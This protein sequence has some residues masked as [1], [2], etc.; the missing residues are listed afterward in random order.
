MSDL[1]VVVTGVLIGSATGIGGAVLGAW[2]NGR[3]QMAGLKLSI[4]AENERAARAERQRA[5][6]AFLTSVNALSVALRVYPHEA[7]D[8]PKR[9]YEDLK[10]LPAA[11][12]LLDTCNELS[13]IAPFAIMMTA[14]EI[15]DVC[16]G[17]VRRV[18]SG[19]AVPRDERSALP[20]LIN[21][22]SHA[23]SADLGVPHPTHVVFRDGSK[24]M[25]QPDGQTAPQAADRG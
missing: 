22:I 6:V 21:R 16:L 8:S 4:A 19:G 20:G 3:S 13:L 23:M 11:Q 2:M 18:E 12:H 24:T 25:S 9:Q 1:G 14:G 17:V 10:L 7:D 15:R 5:Y